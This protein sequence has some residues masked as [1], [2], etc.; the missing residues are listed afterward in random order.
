MEEIINYLKKT[1][2]RKGSSVIK[3][4]PKLIPHPNLSDYTGIKMKNNIKEIFNS[5]NDYNLKLK[6]KTNELIKA[7]TDKSAKEN[8]ILSLRKDL[9]F[10]KNINKNFNIYKQY[11]DDVCDYYK[12]NFEEIYEFKAKLKYDLRDFIKVLD[13]YE[14]QIAECIKNRKAIIK[15]SEDL[16]VFK[17]NEQEKMV[18]QL[19][20]LNYDLEIQG[21]KLSDITEKLNNFK[22]EN[23]ENMLRINN[24]ELHSMENYEMLEAKYKILVAKYDFYINKELK[25]RKL[26]LE[27]KD[28]NLCK[29][30]EDLADL[31][32]QDQLVQNIFLKN[33]A[34]DIKKQIEEV[35]LA[36]KKYLEE[37]EEIKFLGKVFFNKVKQRRMEKELLLTQENDNKSN[38]NTTTVNS[39]T[40]TNTRP[41]ESKNLKLYNKSLREILIKSSKKST[42]KHLTLTSSGK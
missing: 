1:A 17:K 27:Y 33:I 38:K 20:K 24:N 25:R 12:Q 15:T 5:F 36:H 32:L 11:S 6:R 13:G 3:I 34:K 39:K 2:V 7:Q 16:I 31:K 42:P 23:E 8:I 21:E 30:E 9:N 26:E 37:E 19:T 14:D 40:R 35:E 10:H 29:E 22:T 4:R 28:K 18:K 41:N